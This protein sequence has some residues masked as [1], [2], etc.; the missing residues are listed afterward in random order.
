MSVRAPEAAEPSACLGLDRSVA[1]GFERLSAALRGDRGGEVGELLR[2]EREKLVAGLRRLQSTARRLAGADERVD[3]RAGAVDL[4]DH[5]RLP[6]QR[7]F[8]RPDAVFP[9]RIGIG[10]HLGMVA[11]E[12]TALVAAFRSEEH[13]SELQ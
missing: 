5:A 3:R 6:A 2:L 13:T 1:R 11:G 7:I 8:K 10:D 9:A 4:A 12:R